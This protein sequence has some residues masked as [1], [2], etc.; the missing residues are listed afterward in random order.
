MRKYFFFIFFFFSL[1]SYGLEKAQ[2]P[3]IVTSFTIIADMAQNVAG[4]KAI[5][6]S[7]TKANAEIHQYQPTAKDI[8]RVQQADL[9]LWNGM[10]LELWFE[11]FLQD[12][13]DI[14]SVIISEGIEPLSIYDGEYRG[15]PNPHA[16][17]SVKNGLIYVENIR[18]ALT[19]LDPANAEIYNKNAAEYSLKIKAVSENLF[20]RLKNVPPRQRYLV[21][22]EGAFSYLAKDIGFKELYIW[23][24]N[25]DQQGSNKQIR[26]VIDNIR[27]KNIPVIFSESTI[28]D[29]PA[30]QIARETKILY[31]GVLY[32]DSLSKK[33]GPVPTYLDLL[34]VTIKTIADGFEKAGAI[35]E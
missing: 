11:R 10:N 19:V 33:N 28:S 16:W 9:I 18:K 6:E 27:Q 22:S 5:V 26:N 1:F 2:K 29:K 12:V 24:M 25:A 31:G 3:K 13:G 21:T 34:T 14:P 7:I 20:E 17:M 30:K 8:V 4:D 23:P 15:K 35:N 32:V